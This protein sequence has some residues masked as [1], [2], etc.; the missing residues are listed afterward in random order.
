SLSLARGGLAARGFPHLRWA[1]RLYLPVRTASSSVRQPFN[2]YAT[3]VGHGGGPPPSGGHPS[4]WASAE[5]TS[6]TG[7]LSSRG[8]SGGGRGYRLGS[9]VLH[10]RSG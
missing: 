8:K 3:R 5:R 2:G 4:R 6:R 10:A 1:S 9:V 7:A